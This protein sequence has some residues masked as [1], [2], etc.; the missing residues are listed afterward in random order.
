MMIGA[1]FLD[2]RSRR[3]LR[4][5]I[6]CSGISLSIVDLVMKTQEDVFT[7]A[8]SLGLGLVLDRHGIFLFL[9]RPTRYILTRNKKIRRERGD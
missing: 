3:L 9:R 4:F 5:Q 1:P 6:N 8:G 2:R 7:D